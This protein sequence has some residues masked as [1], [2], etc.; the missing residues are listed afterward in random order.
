MPVLDFTAVSLSQQPNFVEPIIV[1]QD[2][3]RITADELALCRESATTPIF[4][5]HLLVFAGDQGLISLFGRDVSQRTYQLVQDYI[6]GKADLMG[7]CEDQAV[8]LLLCDVGVN[9]VFAENTPAFVKFK[10]CAGTRNMMQEP[11]MTIDECE[12]AMDAGRTLVD[13]VAYR[14]CNAVGFGALGTGSELVATILLH[15]FTGRP[16]ADCI[17]MSSETEPPVAMQESVVQQIVQRYS[18]LSQPIEKLAAMGSF[19]IAAIVGGLIQAKENGM[20]V[21]VNGFVPAVAVLLASELAG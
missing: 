18:G 3:L 1:G 9:G 14:D 10:I 7:Y 17:A 8:Q 15:S 4:N 6:G 5:P 12:A 13:G 2:P 19:E 20:T 11:A 16:I 21:V